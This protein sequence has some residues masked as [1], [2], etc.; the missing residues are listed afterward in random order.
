MAGHSIVEVKEKLKIVQN[1]SSILQS[2]AAEK[3]YLL[4]QAQT[5]H[6]LAQNQRNQI[7]QE[8]NK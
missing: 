1:E 7:R 6:L 5:Q 8:L 4:H 2:E 3:E